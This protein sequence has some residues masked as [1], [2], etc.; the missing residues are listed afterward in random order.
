MSFDDV[1]NLALSAIPV[2]GLSAAWTQGAAR[3]KLDVLAEAVAQLLTTLD[4]SF[5]QSKL[6]VANYTIQLKD[7]ERLLNEIHRFVDKEQKRNFLM[8]FLNSG[9]RTSSIEAFYQRIEASCNA[10]QISSAIN[11]Q[12]LLRKNELARMTDMD[13]LHHRLQALEQ[14]NMQLLETIQLSQN[15]MLDMMASIQRALANPQMHHID[16]HFCSHT[17][18]YLTSMSGQQLELEDWMISSLEIDYG[19]QIG[20]GGFG[21]VYRGT[22][23]G[24]DVAI[25]E[26]RTVAGATPSLQL[27]R[28][29]ID[30]WL[31]LRHPNIIQFLGANTMNDTPFLVMP[32]MPYNARQFLRE[33]YDFDPIHLVCNIFTHVGFAMINI[34]VRHSGEAVLCDFGLTRIK[35]E[36]T[37]SSIQM[38][39]TIVA[40]SRN[41]MAPELFVGSS[42][43][44]STDIYAFGMTIYELYTDE[45]PFSSIEHS[46]FREIVFKQQIRPPRPDVEDT[47]MLN[48]EVWTLA[49]QCWLHD[50]KARPLAGTILKSLTAMVQM[51]APPVTPENATLAEVKQHPNVE[52]WV[53]GYS[54]VQSVVVS[55][56]SPSVQQSGGDQEAE[57]QRLKQALQKN[58]RMISTL[59]DRHQKMQ[60]YA[61]A[62]ELWVRLLE[63]QKQVLGE[64]HKDTLCTMT[65]LVKA[66][67]VLK[68]FTKAAEL[69]DTVTIL[70]LFKQSPLQSKSDFKFCS[71]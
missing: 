45:N 10:F 27:M 51:S 28:K 9:T 30:I 52:S 70:A 2:P 56:V 59:V 36:I 11:I 38:G 19:P 48:D 34:L 44:I 16:R 23:N 17:L 50:P 35:S 65:N 62:T 66:Y 24:R 5:K 14:N 26:L 32:Y 25:K 47:P 22:W 33:R 60:Q 20:A 41:W 18:Q 29:E 12:S 57:I 4:S 3:C 71:V 46:E 49:E 40:G 7:L 43:K 6:V 21:T 64:N 42:P 54:A 69:G 37:S 8:A 53:A 63:M 13:I 55:G 31:T 15:N 68:Q 61:K 1:V 39:R 67:G 58:L